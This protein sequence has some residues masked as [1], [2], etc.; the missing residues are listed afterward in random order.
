MATKKQII[1]PLLTISIAVAAMFGLMALKKPPEEKKIEKVIPLVTVRN[2]DVADIELIVTSQGIVEP[3]EQTQLTAQISG[4][5]VELSPVFIKGGL[6]KSGDTLVRIDP[7]D[8]EANLIEAQAN[9]AA[10]RASLQQEKA[11]GRVAEKEW[12]QITNAKPSQLGLRKP[13]LAKEVATVRAAEAVVKKAKRN[14]DRTYIRAPYDAIVESRAV[15]LGSVVGMGNVIG[16]VL[17]VDTAQVRLPIADQDL[18]FLNQQGIGA[19]VEVVSNFEGKAT[20]WFG[21][22]VRNEGVIDKASRMNYLVAEFATPYS[23]TKPLRFGS[24]VSAKISGHRVKQAALVPSHLV[25]NNEIA[26]LTEQNTLHYQKVN[27]IRQQGD[28]VV[29]SNIP[30]A[31]RYISSALDYPVEGM[32]LAI[33]SADL[34]PEQL[35][36]VGGAAK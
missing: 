34:T 23:L 9:L 27:L 36:N 16:N 25:N 7:N 18:A 29:I 19:T 8:Y 11:K 4:Q 1:L 12:Q 10:A 30:V 15:S 20:S 33:P 17:A 13:Q 32:S 31:S 22:I 14:L 5:I 35:A 6:I 26:V 21:K 24:Y 2:V 28:M 3:K